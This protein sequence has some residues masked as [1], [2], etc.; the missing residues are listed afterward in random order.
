MMVQLERKRMKLLPPPS[1]TTRLPSTMA[2]S[3]SS[4]SGAMSPS[5]ATPPQRTVMVS[6]APSGGAGGGMRWPNRHPH[7]LT[8]GMRKA[9]WAL[10]RFLP[11]ID[12]TRFAR[13][14]LSAEMRC[15]DAGVALAGCGDEAQ[16]L[17]ARE[18]GD[19][20]AAG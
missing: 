8:P 3:S 17:A 13:R 15:E 16:A 5:S 19:L 9:Q 10:S 12:W 1:T 7:V 6:L 18:S 4:T 14:N 20:A 2:A 11:L